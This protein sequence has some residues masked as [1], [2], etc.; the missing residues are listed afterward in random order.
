MSDIQVWCEHTK[1]V[2]TK[3]LKPWP[4]NPNVHPKK[5]I[6]LLAKIIKEQGWRA[7]ITV[8]NL[9]GFITK[10]H[11]R[12]E[13]AI[14][15][16]CSH[17][18][19]DFQ[20][21][22]STE[23]EMADILADNKIAELSSRDDELVK[24]MLGQM[25]SDMMEFTGFMDKEIRDLLSDSKNNGEHLNRLKALMQDPVSVVDYEDVIQLGSHVL[26]CV[27]PITGW[28]AFLP[29]LK[30]DTD[31]FC[32]FAGVYTVLGKKAGYKRFVLVNP[33][34]YICGHIVDRFKSA[35]PNE[36]VKKLS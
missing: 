36:P 34:S 21:Y 25:P 2:P 29:Y 23:A 17:V 10:G 16:K 14:L 12:R 13:A 30:A 31:L 28:K 24:I 7:P 22:P 19:V 20:D 5:Q 8:S 35:F 15:L 32:P 9:S 4:K 33:N 18:P 27:N 3:D 6:E 1:L 26:I 11:G